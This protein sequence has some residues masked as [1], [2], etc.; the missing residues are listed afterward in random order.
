MLKGK[1]AIITG[2][3]RGIGFS[4]VKTFL[5]NGAN[6]AMLGSKKE[7][8]TNALAKLQQYVD[9]GQLIGFYPDLNNTNQMK[10]TIELVYQ[11]FHRIDI[12]VNNAG[13]SSNTA[14][15]EYD[16]KELERIFNLNIKAVVNCSKAVIPYMKQHGGSIINTS[17]MVSLYGQP[18]GAAYPMS[19]YAV[20]G[21]SLIHI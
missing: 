14:F 8:V 3:T 20:N 13:I 5:E 2:G 4:T 21:L 15:E 18:S 19:K 17:S 6:V 7:T 11:Q 9:N 10:E 16:E 1:T 12:L